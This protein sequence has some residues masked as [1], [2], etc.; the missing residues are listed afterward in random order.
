MRTSFFFFSLLCALPVLC[1]K[2]HIHSQDPDRYIYSDGME[3][4]G[5]LVKTV[6]KV[7]E[8][9]PPYTVCDI[10][11]DL[12]MLV[13]AMKVVTIDAPISDTEPTTG[14]IACK[15]GKLFICLNK[16]SFLPFWSCDISLCVFISF[17]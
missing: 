17:V 7:V 9:Y 3:K 6:G 14:P 5:D 16:V 15:V 2:Y 11:G 13:N 4:P 12:E 1:H 8:G 10:G